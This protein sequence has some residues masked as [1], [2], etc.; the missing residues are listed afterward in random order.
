M[1]YTPSAVAPTNNL[2][3]VS[4]VAGILSFFAHVVPGVGGLAVAIVAIVTG[5]MARKQIK[6][7]GE[8]GM[9]MANAGIV[10]GFIH[11]ALIAVVVFA[12]LFVILV[13]GIALF[14]ASHH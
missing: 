13:L 14:G 8:Q 4:L 11:L 9:W 5:Y 1:F 12:L 6:Q 7:S 10:I 2:A 3:V